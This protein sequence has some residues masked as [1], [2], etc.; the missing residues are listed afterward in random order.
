MLAQQEVLRGE[1]AVSDTMLVKGG[2]QVG[3]GIQDRLPAPPRFGLAGAPVVRDPVDQ[4]RRVRQEGGHEEATAPLLHRGQGGG[5][6]D[7][8]GAA[9]VGA[10]PGVATPGSPQAI[11]EALHPPAAYELLDAEQG[12]TR[13]VAG[14]ARHAPAMVGLDQIRPPPSDTFVVVFQCTL[15]GSQGKLATAEHAPRAATLAGELGS[16]RKTATGLAV[17]LILAGAIQAGLAKARAWARGSRDRAGLCHGRLQYTSSHR[18]GQRATARFVSDRVGDWRVRWA[19][20][21]PIGPLTRALGDFDRGDDP[22]GATTVKRSAARLVLRMP[23]G[24]DQAVFWKCYRVRSARERLRF[25]VVRSRARQEFENLL[26]LRKRGFSTVEP[27]ACAERRDGPWPGRALLA[28]RELA[29][30]EP[31]AEALVRQASEV[32]GETIA[33]LARLARGLHDAGWWHRDLHS[34]NVLVT[35]DSKRLVLVDVQKMRRVPGALP[36]FLRVRD[37]GTL[38]HD[39]GVR[40]GPAE[41]ERVLETYV[42]SGPS[43]LALAPLRVRVEH[44]AA[45]RARR[46]MRSRARRCVVDSTGFRVERVGRYRIFRRTDVPLEHVFETLEAHRRGGGSS[47]RVDGVLGGPPPGPAPN[48]FH[49]AQGLPEP[50]APALAAVEVRGFP[51]RHSIGPLGR[52]PGML[53]WRKAHAALLRG[54]DLPAP[55]ALVEERV[56]GCVRRAWLLQRADGRLGRVGCAVPL[57]DPAH[58]SQ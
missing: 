37:L 36:M 4:G 2:H 56:F 19:P 9:G 58:G 10:E 13:V 41:R 27:L 22:P 8:A 34:G 57:Q 20:D 49:R 51:G 42:A 46:R 12:P 55:L 50:G 1:I 26:R 45:R 38:V 29:G 18:L 24:E 5:H 54:V 39:L 43:E 14:H 11:A 28:T 40:V 6:R 52:H 21:A 44:A 33:G 7:A 35:P 47:T 15:Q 31:L 25:S 17:M 30:A 3:G 53:A 23:L 32:R 48:P 16:A